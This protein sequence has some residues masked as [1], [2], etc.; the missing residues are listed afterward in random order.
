MKG[1]LLEDCL[2]IKRTKKNRRKAE[3]FF[4]EKRAAPTKKE[5]PSLSKARPFRRDFQP[6]ESW[7]SGLSVYCFVFCDLFM[8]SC[9]FCYFV[10]L[11]WKQSNT[12]NPLW[13]RM[14]LFHFSKISI[15]S[16]FLLHCSPV[17]LATFIYIILLS[18]QTNTTTRPT[19]TPSATGCYCIK[20]G[21]SR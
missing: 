13:C 12:V 1:R 8:L 21:Y 11:V 14:I 17:T 10:E 9:C 19:I 3:R 18:T 2:T 16:V 20:R 15:A 7:K 5:A 4:R 6:F